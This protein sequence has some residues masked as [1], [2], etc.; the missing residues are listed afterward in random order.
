MIK[1]DPKCPRCGGKHGVEVSGDGYEWDCAACGGHLICA[2]G[3]DGGEMYPY[4]REDGSCGCASEPHTCDLDDDPSELELVTKERDALRVAVS[5]TCVERDL[6]LKCIDDIA[7]VLGDRGTHSFKHER[8]AEVLEMVRKIAAER[9]ALDADL[10][11][12][13]VSQPTEEQRIAIRQLVRILRG[14]GPVAYQHGV[15][16]IERLV[17]KE[18]DRA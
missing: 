9:D 15:D 5:R 4:H 2:I 16:A 11:T 17:G 12:L 8:S 13:R 18:Q 10:A 3:P 7:T 1:M 14:T 6:Y